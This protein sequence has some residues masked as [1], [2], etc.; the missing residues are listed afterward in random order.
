MLT[1]KQ[2]RKREQEKALEKSKVARLCKT[3]GRSPE[4]K[5]TIKKRQDNDLSVDYRHDVS[6]HKSMAGQYLDS[7]DV[8]EAEVENYAEREANAQ[9]EIAHK[10]KCTAPLYSK[11]PYQY[12]AGD[13]DLT[14]VGRK[15]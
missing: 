7:P 12:V 6:P 15:V 3:L 14:T 2:Q 4:G 10:K 13:V 8:F 9:L 5:A 11:G 1:R